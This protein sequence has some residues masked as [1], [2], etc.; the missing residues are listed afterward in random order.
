MHSSINFYSFILATLHFQKEQ[1]E[2]REIA[3]ATLRNFVKAIKL[4]C[5]MSDISVPWK[6]IARRLPKIRRCANDRAPTIE[7]IGQVISRNIK[8]GHEKDYGDWLRRYMIL[9][10]NVPGY[11]GDDNNCSWWLYFLCAVHC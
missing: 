4:F 6:K 11:L 8:P 2:K 10:N 5:E 1:V 9:E 3:G 7:E